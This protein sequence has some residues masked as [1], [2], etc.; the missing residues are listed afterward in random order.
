MIGN[1]LYINHM[2]DLAFD[3]DLLVCAQNF[4]TFTLN[5][6]KIFLFIVFI[7]Y[8]LQAKVSLLASAETYKAW[9]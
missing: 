3:H 4:Q 7:F 5:G 8:D 2:V 6:H 1:L 9:V